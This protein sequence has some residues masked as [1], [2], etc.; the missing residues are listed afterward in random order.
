MASPGSDTAVPL[1]AEQK[2]VFAGLA[3][4]MGLLSMLLLLLAVLRLVSAGLAL[5]G[6]DWVPGLL[7]VAEGLAAGFMGLVLLTGSSDARFVA[8]TNGY[9]KSHFLNTVA[10]LA[11]FYTA[12]VVVGVLVALVLAIRLFVWLWGG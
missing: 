7:S 6:G 10:S 9:E 5:W 12:Q 8:E 3:S 4:R 11:T 2:R 1:S